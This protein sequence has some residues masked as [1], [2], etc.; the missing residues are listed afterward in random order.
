MILLTKFNC[1]QLKVTNELLLLHSQQPKQN[2]Y[3]T[4]LH[5]FDPYLYSELEFGNHNFP[6]HEVVCKLQCPILTMHLYT[7]CGGLTHRGLMRHICMNNYS[8]IDSDN[9]LSPVRHQAI[10]STNHGLLLLEPLGTKLSE[11]WIKMKHFS[12]KKMHLKTLS[13]EWRPFLS[14]WHRY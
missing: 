7:L 5:I 9:G 10:I 11:I 6:Y 8:R 13:A 2:L 1:I 14:L 3:W 4:A 12:H